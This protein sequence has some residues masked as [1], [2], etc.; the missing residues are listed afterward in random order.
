MY[1][2][3]N[4]YI[5][6]LQLLNL[7]IIHHSQLTLDSNHYQRFKLITFLNSFFFFNIKI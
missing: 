2:N 6:I 5:E 7:L 1:I 4:Y 3:I